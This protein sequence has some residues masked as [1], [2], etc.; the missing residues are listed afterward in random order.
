MKDTKAAGVWIDSEKAI[1]VKNHDGQQVTE[2]EVTD[3]FKHEKQHGNSSEN[4]ANNSE[5][6]TKTKFFKDIDKALENTVE[7]FITGP[8]TI[9]EELK[10]YLHDTAQFKDLKI[11]L[12]ASQQMSDEA[13]LEATK[14]HFGA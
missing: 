7:L 10:S 1:L 5:Q 3:H 8:G 9:Q 2:F 4:A 12:D 11:T 14:K 13:V 6:T